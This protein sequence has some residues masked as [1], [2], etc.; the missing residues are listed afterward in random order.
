MTGSALL[1]L[2]IA[3][4]MFYFALSMVCSSLNDAVARVLKWRAA[5]LFDGVRSLLLN[6]K[7]PAIDPVTNQ[8]LLDPKTSAPIH[9]ELVD[10]FFNHPFI[11]TL[12]LQAELGD[13]W[14]ARRLDG[15]WGRIR[16]AAAVLRGSPISA[17]VAGNG[18]LDP[19]T[20]LTSIPAPVFVQ[21]L[22]EVL[23]PAGWSENE[24][25]T[26]AAFWRALDQLPAKEAG[27]LKQVLKSLAIESG[28]D[29][30]VVRA[31]LAK[32]FD[33]GMEQA[34]EW[35]RK[36]MRTCSILVGAVLCFALNIDSIDIANRFYEDAN[37]RG[38]YVVAASRLNQ[39]GDNPPK[40]A[41]N[42]APPPQTAEPPIN[43]IKDLHIGWEPNW[44]TFLAEM[45]K[46]MKW[47]GLIIS[48]VALSMG[49]PF[50]HDLI[51][52]LITRRQSTPA[53]TR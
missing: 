27:P 26:F 49:A 46:V 39:T 8:P 31:N 43:P 45:Q 35:Y 10:Q 16:Q 6:A 33:A 20:K 28:Q 19:L 50:W 7:V 48:V 21:A 40:P 9:A 44:D 15:F 4:A 22:C 29:M 25:L 52:R 34:S 41:A 11:Q 17:V 2:F 13:S 23:K 3:M 5:T 42:G 30:T 47:V 38:V 53:A 37:L 18:A 32:W 36:R 1:D 51:G 14:L 24:P 12:R